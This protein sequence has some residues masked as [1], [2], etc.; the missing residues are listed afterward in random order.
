M[1]EQR[2]L[3]EENV[4]E[5]EAKLNEMQKDNPDL[6]YRFFEQHKI[7]NF[8]KE[9]EGLINKHSIENECDVPDFILAEMVVGFIQSIG[10]QVK[11]TLDWHGCDSVC[12]PVNKN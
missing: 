3:T 5:L 2:N 4:E 1:G 11:K 12:H 8:Q 6:E 10:P 7:D 9:L